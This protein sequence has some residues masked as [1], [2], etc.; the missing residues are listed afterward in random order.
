M[1]SGKVRFFAIA[2]LLVPV[3][4]L[5]QPITTNFTASVVHVGDGDS[6]RVLRGM[7][8][9]EI[10]LASI[11]APELQQM[12]GAEC[13]SMLARR[14]L[15]QRV[16]V[17]PITTDRYGRTVAE[18]TIGNENINRFMVRGGCA[19]AYRAHLHDR[20]MIGLERLARSERKGVW[21]LPANQRIPPWRFRQ[22]NR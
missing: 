4:V 1:I 16:A 10:R 3:L 12:L 15:N 9:V 13:K 6:I 5:A 11:D 21:G 2:T 14:V 8:R 7:R 20:Q 22:N 17:H 19:W 18:I